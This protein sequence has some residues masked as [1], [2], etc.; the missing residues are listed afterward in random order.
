MTEAEVRKVVAEAVSDTLLK[1]GIEVDDPM[2][3]QRDLQFLR[4]WR[5]SSNTIKDKSIATAVAIVVSGFL[6]LLYMA[7]KGQ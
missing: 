1:L 2:E 3:V 7:F 6:G 4:G 5:Q